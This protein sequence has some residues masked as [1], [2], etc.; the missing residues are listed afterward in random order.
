MVLDANLPRN[1]L[2][3]LVDKVGHN[4][5]H[6]TPKGIFIPRILCGKLGA[7]ARAIGGALLPF[8]ANFHRIKP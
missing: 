2:E 6:F 8:Y 3:R 4:I 1:L 7:D 5:N